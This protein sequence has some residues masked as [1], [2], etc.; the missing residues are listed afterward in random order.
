M[1]IF[2]KL[3]SV[4]NLLVVALLSFVPD[5][6]A[7]QEQEQ[8][9]SDAQVASGDID[10]MAPLSIDL[11]TEAEQQNFTQNSWL[12]GTRVTLKHES[13]T[14]ITSDD[15]LV[16][17]RSS[18]QFELDKFFL[19]NYFIRLDTK[20][21]GYWQNDHQNESKSHE[22]LTREAFLQ[23]S[24]G[25]SSIKLGIQSLIWG[26]SDGGAITD[27][28]SPRN[29]TELFFINL[30]EARLGQP[31]VQ[32]DHFSSIGDFNAF[33]IPS[34]DMNEYPESGTEYY[35]NPFGDQV[36]LVTDNIGPSEGEFGIRW[37][38]TFG[39]SD[40]ALMAARVTDN[41]YAIK[42]MGFDESGKLLLKQQ[43]QRFNMLGMTFNTVLDKWLISGE[44]AYKSDKAFNDAQ[45][46]YFE[47]SMID[48]AVQVEYSISGNDRIGLELV[49]KHIIDFQQDTLVYPRNANQLIFTYLMFFF[50]EDLM[51][52]WQSTYT[53]PFSSWQHSWRSTYEWDDNLS[54]NI[55]LHFVEVTD[56]A[57]ELN[58]Y[59]QQDQLVFKMLYQF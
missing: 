40:L 8:A 30:E 12:E 7:Q 18:V 37:G 32:F 11:Y 4:H 45:L 42:A 9:Q 43:K 49:N 58:P 17:N 44:L 27:V 20:L 26:E 41:D 14:K 53:D 35:F 21:T 56:F 19:D 54:F 28:I 55:D 23:A 22:L 46:N 31:M 10:L 38:K 51:V 2:N 59:R 1:M 3:P 57:A 50:N 47:R 6:L 29:F 33:Y 36:S 34:P 24:F 5:G 52:H 13:S 39:N 48:S 15:G 25:D 16:N